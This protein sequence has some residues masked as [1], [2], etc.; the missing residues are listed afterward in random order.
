MRPTIYDTTY[1][2]ELVENDE[3]SP[4]EAGF[5]YWYDQSKV[6]L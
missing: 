4:Q 5:M 2:D 3:I 1:V 6:E